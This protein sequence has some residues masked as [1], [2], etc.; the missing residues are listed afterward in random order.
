M[1]G[2]ARARRRPR[3]I[4]VSEFDADPAGGS[5]SAEAR[6]IAKET[7]EKVNKAMGLYAAT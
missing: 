7:I 1:E 3:S 5:P 6:P 2:S 4:R